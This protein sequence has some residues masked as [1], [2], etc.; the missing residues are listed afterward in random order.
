V[1]KRFWLP[2]AW[3]TDASAVRR[4]TGQVPT[5]VTWPSKPQWAATMW[6]AI[7]QAGL[8]PC[9]DVVAACL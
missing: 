1:D 8:L 9:K 2:E 6:P 7:V 5:E 4:A 3:W